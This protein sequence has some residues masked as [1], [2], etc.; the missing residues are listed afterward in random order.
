MAHIEKLSADTKIQ[1][2]LGP[3]S[4]YP[5]IPSPASYCTTV[6]IQLPP[7][8]NQLASG[9]PSSSASAR[10]QCSRTGQN[11]TEVPRSPTNSTSHGLTREHIT[12]AVHYVRFELARAGGGVTQGWCRLRLGP[13]AYHGVRAAPASH[14][15]QG[16]RTN[17]VALS[18]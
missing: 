18:G 1:T 16:L 8:T 2:R 13:P 10:L 12:A 15:P 17:L 7:P 6:F 9:C 14:D 3:R 5:L 11:S 4:D